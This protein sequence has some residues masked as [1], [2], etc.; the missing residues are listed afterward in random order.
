MVGTLLPAGITLGVAYYQNRRALEVKI[1]QD[2]LSE[3]SQ[4]A[5]EISVW[6]KERLYDLRVFAGSDEVVAN[7]SRYASQGL[8]S[9]RLREYLRSVHAR[10]PDFE[11]LMV[12]D[13]NGRLLATS[14]QQATPVHLPQDWQKTLRQRGQVVG[15]AYW[16]SKG[17]KGKL[18]VAVPVQRA[19]GHP[20]GAFAVEIN[21]APVQGQLRT[22]LPDG[23]AGIVYLTN[24]SG[25][26]IASSREISQ[27]LLG[28][29]LSPGTLR[30]LSQVQDAALSFVDFDGREVLRALKK[31]PS[32]EQ[33]SVVA[34][35]P[36]DSAFEQVRRFRN[37]AFALIAVLLIAVAATAYR[38][39]LIIV[40]P[41]QRLAEGA[42]EVSMG[43][44]DVDLPA[45]TSSSGEVGA[46][47]S[48]FNHMVS[49]LRS[50]REELATANNE[51]LSKNEELER[52]SVTD[53]LTGLVNHR[54]LMQRL[55]EEGVRSQ[56]HKHA[57]IVI[58]ADVD[59]FKNYND[60]FGHPEGDK[61]L[62][63]V[64]AILKDSTR[65][66]DCVARYGGEEFAVLLPETEMSG[67]V[68]VAERMRS[69]VESAEFPGR[70]ITLSIGIAEFPKDGETPK[71]IIVVADAALYVAKREGRNQVARATPA[72]K[73]HRLPAARPRKSTATKK[74]S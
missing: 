74:K 8:A 46:L 22:F 40:R 49:R 11:Q 27:G 54:A 41:L 48:V 34:E 73:K 14:A 64:A 17:N 62:K 1:T 4:T 37:V 9:P 23:G 29:R 67:G 61:V 45:D 72:S 16:D 20:I 35:I 12:L 68:E 2:L 31:V 19:D 57:F 58:M 69:R 18:V 5:R 70:R 56:R 15:D 60:E 6:L 32:V 24:D 52:L 66:V 7:L 71:D 59:H 65:T 55:S 33:W 42:A 10:F 25:R 39:G 36:A 38:L 47:T 3:S 63:K 21:L 30:R 13:P 26:V 50:G 51:L 44:L 43:D 53:G 28:T